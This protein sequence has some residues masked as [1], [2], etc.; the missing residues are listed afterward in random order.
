MTLKN[1][2]G[3]LQSCGWT[4]SRRGK[5]ASRHTASCPRKRMCGVFLKINFC[6]DFEGD[7]DKIESIEEKFNAH[8]A[9]FVLGRIERINKTKEK[10]LTNFVAT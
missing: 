10:Q 1:V 3:S 4:R 8:C 7:W 5:D 9:P 6:L 2:L